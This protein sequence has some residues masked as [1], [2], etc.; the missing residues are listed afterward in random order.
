MNGGVDQFLVGRL[1][2]LQFKDTVIPALPQ[3]LHFRVRSG[4]LISIITRAR[5]KEETIC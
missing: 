5:E 1:I 2:Q 4:E 3:D